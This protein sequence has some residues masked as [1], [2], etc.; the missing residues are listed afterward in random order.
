[1]LWLYENCFHNLG[2]YV[3]SDLETPPGLCCL[4][5]VVLVVCTSEA[6]P[7]C[8]LRGTRLDRDQ[9]SEFVMKSLGFG[10]LIVMSFGS[11]QSTVGKAGGRT[12]AKCGRNEGS[13]ITE[14]CE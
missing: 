14:L 2:Q 12:G 3:T 8:K 11:R 7:S 9:E 5:I 6:L 1:M 4:A 13:F 10:A